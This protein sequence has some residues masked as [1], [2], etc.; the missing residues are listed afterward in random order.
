MSITKCEF[1]T[2]LVVY[3]NDL[4]FT[5]LIVSTLSTYKI[6]SMKVH[7]PWHS[8]SILCRAYDKL[9]SDQHSAYVVCFPEGKSAQWGL[10]IEEK[11]SITRDVCER[12]IN[13]GEHFL[14]RK[15]LLFSLI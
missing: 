9:L 8:T 7:W 15:A 5:C 6:N 4:N 1:S 11:F 2:D 14:V 13:I 10:E 3:L 12:T